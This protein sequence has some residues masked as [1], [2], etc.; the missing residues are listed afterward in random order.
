MTASGFGCRHV[1]G[2]WLGAPGS[3]L[4]GPEGFRTRTPHQIYGLDAPCS[5]Q[6][7]CVSVRPVLPSLQLHSA[8]PSTDVTACESVPCPAGPVMAG[9]PLPAMMN[10][11]A[12]GAV[13]S[14][15][16]A[17][18]NGA[19][20]A[21]LDTAAPPAFPAHASFR[22]PCLDAHDRN[23]CPW[24]APPR[25]RARSCSPTPPPQRSCR[26]GVRRRS[27]SGCADPHGAPPG[28]A[29]RALRE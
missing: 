19:A 12:G 4:P 7:L 26:G 29:L 6:A 28:E 5:I 9:S 23:R 16:G 24:P 11:Y 2:L 14:P 18:C 1:S 22:P 15:E 17:Q 10:A 21:R 13:V 25:P 20:A 3:W 27:P 8:Q